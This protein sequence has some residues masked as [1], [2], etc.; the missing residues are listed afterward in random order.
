MKHPSTLI[1]GEPLTN[2]ASR[3]EAFFA[4]YQDEQVLS[5]AHGAWMRA[6]YSMHKNGNL[7]AMNK[8]IIGNNKLLILKP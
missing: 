1:L 7:D 4:R 2:L 8:H 3:V 6:A 5:F